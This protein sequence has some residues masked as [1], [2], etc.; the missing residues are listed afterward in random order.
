M[1]YAKPFAPT[2][3]KSSPEQGREGQ[4]G[5]FEVWGAGFLAVGTVCGALG[6]HALKAV[7]SAGSL[8][9]W[10]TASMYML[11]MGV[12]LIGANRSTTTLA[13]QRMLGAV[14]L[15]TCLFSGSIVGL[16][17]L[18]GMEGLGSLKAVLGPLTPIGGLLMIGGWAG[19][20]WIRHL[21]LK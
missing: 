13:A 20:A 14:V 17:A 4:A 16:V 5:R 1:G 21:D 8:D 18:S 3:M 11:V 6:A 7:L 10:K 9:S 19:W 12:G 15:G 2:P